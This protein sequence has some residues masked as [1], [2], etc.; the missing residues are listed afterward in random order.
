MSKNIRISPTHG[1]NPSLELCFFCGEAKGVVLFGMIK[2]R[3]AA[4]PEAPREVCLDKEPCDK[5]KGFMEQGIILIGCDE[6]KSEDDPHNP[7]RDGNWCV[8]TEDYI[9]R[10][11][12]TDMAEDL[13]RKRAGF[14]GSEAWKLMGLPVPRGDRGGSPDGMSKLTQEGED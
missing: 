3:V 6:A 13:C 9:R 8:V 11:F 2:S 10:T 12:H 14:V 1:V 7:Y 4:D 5:C